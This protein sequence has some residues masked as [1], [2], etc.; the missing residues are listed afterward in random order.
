[1]NS[2]LNQKPL[3]PV[4]I[5]SYVFVFIL[6]IMDMFGGQ[7]SQLAGALAMLAVTFVLLTEIDWASIIKLVGGNTGPAAT[8]VGGASA[9][10]PRQSGD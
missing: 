1:M 8:D 2:W 10:I 3:T 4:I 9:P 7:M 5:G 6:S